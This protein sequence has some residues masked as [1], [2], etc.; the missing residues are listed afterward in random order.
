M[1]NK[2]PHRDKPER[3]GVSLI[4][5]HWIFR[6]IDFVWGHNPFIC[7][8]RRWGFKCHRY[9]PGGCKECGRN[10]IIEPINKEL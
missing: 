7:P 1:N 5:L 3:G 9:Y 2:K 10:A 8:Y 6:C 4:I